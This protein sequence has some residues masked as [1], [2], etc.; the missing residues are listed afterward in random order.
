[1]YADPDG[2]VDLHVRP[3][4]EHESYARLSIEADADGETAQHVL[5]LR[6]GREPAEQMPFPP[7]AEARWRP[8]ADA[9]VRPALGLDES[10]TIFNSGGYRVWSRGAWCVMPE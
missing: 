9:Q 8:P 7:A 5:E 1:M 4:G 6:P 2:F 10:L 3:S